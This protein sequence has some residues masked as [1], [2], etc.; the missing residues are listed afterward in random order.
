LA[1]ARVSVSGVLEKFDG[2]GTNPTNLV[3]RIHI[4]DDE[5]VK[6]EFFDAGIKTGEQIVE[7]GG[8]I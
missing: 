1:Q 5:I 2:E 7:E 6:V 8:T 3:E 4:V